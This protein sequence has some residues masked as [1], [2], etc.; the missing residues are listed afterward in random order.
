MK[1]ELIPLEG[2]IINGNKITF[3]MPIDEVQG[4]GKPKII[5]K[6]YYYLEGDLMIE[7]DWRRRICFVECRG[8]AE[9][10]VHPIIYGMDFFQTKAE[11]ALALLE[12][13]TKEKAEKSEEGHYYEWKKANIGLSRTATMEEI[14]EMIQET[15]EDGEYEE[16]KEDLERDRRS[17][18]C[19]ETIGIGKQGYY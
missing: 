4:I 3:G 19:F 7:V 6:L 13:H 2:V 15:I 17:A 1:V 9:S 5:K 11:D 8:G 12:Q 10:K 14:E 16:M 18:Y